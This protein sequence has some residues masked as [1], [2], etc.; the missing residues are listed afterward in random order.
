MGIPSQ[1]SWR[2]AA[3]TGEIVAK[4]LQRTTDLSLLDQN[5]LAGSKVTRRFGEALS[6]VRFVVELLADLGY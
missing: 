1:L 4:V 6:W 3:S 5:G 2:T